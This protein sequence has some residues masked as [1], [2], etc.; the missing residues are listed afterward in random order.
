MAAETASDAKREEDFSD[1]GSEE[2]NAGELL[3]AALV[4]AAEEG[5]LLDVRRLLRAGADA[6]A[7]AGDDGS[8]WKTPLVAAAAV[9]HTRIVELLLASGAAADGAGGGADLTPLHVAARDGHARVV[10]AL[11]LRGADAGRATAA[12]ATARELAADAACAGLLDAALHPSEG[13]LFKAAAAGRADEVRILLAR[14]IDVNRPRGCG[15]GC[16]DSSCHGGSVSDYSETPLHAAARAGH[17]ACVRHLLAAGADTEIATDDL[18]CIAIGTTPLEE[19]RA[20]G[21][22]EAA[23]VLEEAGAAE[24]TIRGFEGFCLSLNL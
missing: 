8:P 7:A 9:G 20:G 15:G 10:A 5:S 13:L 12:G 22:A 1:D 11:L 16:A 6:N 23:R 24:E 2:E 18:W 17:A 3:S 19:A 4:R 21:H 14:G